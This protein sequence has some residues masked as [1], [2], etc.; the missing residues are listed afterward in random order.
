MGSR[1]GQRSRHPGRRRAVRARP[2]GRCP[3]TRDRSGRCAAMAGPC[4]GAGPAGGV[5][6]ACAGR[7]HGRQRCACGP[8]RCPAL[9]TLATR[10]I[11]CLNAGPRPRQPRWRPAHHAT[12]GP[13]GH[14]QP[15]PRCA[16]RGACRDHQFSGWPLGSQAPADRGPR[17][18]P[19]QH[20]ARTHA[21]D[22][23][24]A[25]IATRGWRRAHRRQRRMERRCR[26]AHA[27]PAGPAACPARRPRSP[28][29]PGRHN[30]A[31][32]RRPAR[33]RRL[34]AR[35]CPANAAGADCARRS[36]RRARRESGGADR[37]GRRGAQRQ[38]L[39]HRAARRP[40]KPRRCTG[41]RQCRH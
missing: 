19:G 7:R 25:G 17:A 20:L 41:R 4:R 28:D 3:R 35:G 12:L 1:A 21:A 6:A 8:G 37:A 10:G 18:R 29:D 11:D 9:R 16:D 13:R 34:N 22:R 40:C 5:H 38:R 36:R 31:A 24:A 23:A 33:A 30:L 15:R 14:R 26:P 39:A 2:A 27:A 32:A